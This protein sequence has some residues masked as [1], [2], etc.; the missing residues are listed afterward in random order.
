VNLPKLLSARSRLQ[1]GLPHEP[2]YGMTP[3]AGLPKGWQQP[4]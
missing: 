1:A 2:L 4:G 3:L